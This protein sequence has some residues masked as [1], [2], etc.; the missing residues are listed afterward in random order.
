MSKD[1]KRHETDA[2]R[3]GLETKTKRKEIKS[4]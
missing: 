4:K 1:R 2:Q 3:G